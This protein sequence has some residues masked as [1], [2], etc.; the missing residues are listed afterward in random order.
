V[1]D[2]RPDAGRLDAQE[3]PPPSEG[4][5]RITSPDIGRRP[6]DLNTTGRQR[7]G[8]AGRPNRPSNFP[9]SPRARDAPRRGLLHCWELHNSQRWR[10]TLNERVSPRPRRQPSTPDPT[11]P[12]RPGTPLR[13]LPRRRDGHRRAR[14]AARRAT[15]RGAA[16]ELSPMSA[17]SA[18]PS[19]GDPFAGARAAPRRSS[20]LNPEAG[21]AVPRR[22]DTAILAAPIRKD[23]FWPS[24]RLSRRGSRIW[25]WQSWPLRYKS[26]P[27][28]CAAD[29]LAGRRAGRDVRPARSTRSVPG[30]PAA[31]RAIGS[32]AGSSSTTPRP[33][34]PH[35]ADPPRGGHALQASSG[36][37][38]PRAIGRAKN[39]SSTRSS[40]ATTPSITTRR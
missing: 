5:V 27:G 29:H 25:P 14:L 2:G 7:L 23:A 1:A 20:A 40:S 36:P 11:M 15:P 30:P 28:S 12:R 4:H 9:R 17:G 33:A 16:A 22:T 6:L 38:R 31:A 37:G 26:A 8:P 35:E 32:A 34:G 39:E 21:R 18:R 24:D 19:R 10:P 3:R 13:T